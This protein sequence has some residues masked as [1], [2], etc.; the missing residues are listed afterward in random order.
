MN[1]HLAPRSAFAW[2]RAGL[3]A[4]VAGLL[5]LTP[6]ARAEPAD[7]ADAPQPRKLEVEAHRD[8]PYYGGKDADEVRHKLDVFAPKGGQGLPVVFF[9]HGGAWIAGSKDFPGFYTRVGPFFARHGVV[10]VLPN[11]RLSPAVK[12]PEHVRDAAR[13]LAWTVK[14]VAD[15]GGDP[16]KIIVAGHSAGGHLAALLA[17]D[18]SYLQAEG[19]KPSAIR[20]VMALSGVYTIPEINLH[21]TRDDNGLRTML[22]GSE[23]GPGAGF[24]LSLPLPRLR[25]AASRLA[26]DLNLNP[27]ALAFP[28]DA[29]A[30]RR[31]SPIH[32]VRPGLPP[33]LVAYADHD[34]VTLGPMAETFAQA[35]K[36]CRCDV[37]LLKACDRN[38]RTILTSCDRPDDPV[39]RA[40]LEFV[41][42][43]AR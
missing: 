34:H 43:H 41:E 20:G 7:P 19:L 29:E 25:R 24:G 1:P 10:A 11:Y 38:H 3:P 30:R 39:G 22:S 31:A 6:A 12:H 26:F 37:R 8:L 14:H 27:F 42:K 28:G 4:A 5:F 36:D 35:L 21:V 15:Y 40:M 17:T 23:L 9:L 16:R 32:H 13:A 33:F 2:L 18:P